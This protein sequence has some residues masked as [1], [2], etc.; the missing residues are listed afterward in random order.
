MCVQTD[1]QFEMTCSTP[2]LFSPLNNDNLITPPLK[3]RTNQMHTKSLTEKRDENYSMIQVES[4]RIV[5]QK[6]FRTSLKT[7]F[8]IRLAK[9]V[10]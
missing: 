5:N 4:D 6:T 9:H 8:D 3:Q 1:K 10:I 2:D 7:L